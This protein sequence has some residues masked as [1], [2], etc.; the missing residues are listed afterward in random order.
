MWLAKAC[1]M[2]EVSQ[3]SGRASGGKQLTVNWERSQPAMGESLA[4]VGVGPRAGL[5][6][7][8][9]LPGS[10]SYCFTLAAAP[11]GLLVPSHWL[12][13]PTAAERPVAVTAPTADTHGTGWGGAL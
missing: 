7:G 2:Q 11:R 4:G 12:F 6:A 3:I 1:G 10:S 5:D 8:L 13:M 9:S